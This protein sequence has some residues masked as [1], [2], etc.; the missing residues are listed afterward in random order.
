MI[1]K[2]KRL[3][4][5]NKMRLLVIFPLIFII[6]L[7][8]FITTTSYKKEV[9][10]KNV[11][12]LIVLNTKISLLLHETQKERGA[13]A[14]YLGSKGKKFKDILEKQRNLTNERI[15]EFKTYL[16]GFSY[17]PSK[18]KETINKV[19]DDLSKI[20]K[21]RS[22]IDKL[23]IKAKNAIGFYTNLNANLLYFIAKSSLIAE[24][25]LI[26]K[27][28]TAYY[29]FLMSKERAGIERAVGSNVF[30][31]GTF[32]P[33]VFLKFLTLINEQDAYIKSFYVYNSEKEEYVREKFKNPI[34]DEVQRMRDILLS[35]DEN[36][37]IVFDV[38]P[39]Y[40]FTTITKKINILKEVDDY[41][42]K[43]IIKE[44]S[45]IE[46]N[47]YNK[48][49]L[50]AILS[51]VIITIVLLFV[52]FFIG[53]INRGIDKI[54]YGIEDFIKYLNKE[55]NEVEY[56][57][58]G[59]KGS[60][61]NLAKMINSNID[62]MNGNLEKDL[63]CVGEA[64]ITLDKVEKGYY[65]CRVKSV[66]ANPQVR[67]L[68]NTINKMLDNQQKVI[69]DILKVLDEYTNY[70]YLSVINTK[71]LNGESLQMVEGINGL[72]ESITSMLVE[73]K[74]NGETLQKGSNQ[75]LKNVDELNTAS[76][77]A[78]ARLEET[79]AA[80]EEI[81]SNINSSSQNIAQMAKNANELTISANDGEKLANKTVSSMDDINTQ[82][83]AINEAITVID[84]IAFQTNIL[85]LNAAVEAATAGEAGKGFAV[86]AQEVRNLA[87]R[88]AEA[89]NEI[90]TL[91]ENASSKSKEG[92][93]IADLM[94]NGYHN[95]NE[96]ISNTLSLIDEVENS[97]KEQKYGIEQISDA[98]NSLDKQTQVNANI[99]NHTNDI[100]GETAS[101]AKNVVE[102]TSSKEFR[103]K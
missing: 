7:S 29:N 61:G 75:L 23:E 41:L 72:G 77:D 38:E 83:S 33:G 86:V 65:S 82:V 101:L 70:N 30:A 91:V 22:G 93:D 35:Y 47:E 80:V 62:R 10:L 53:S 18:G 15:E 51:I 66:A 20:Q 50:I 28:I 54:Y 24:D 1:L 26:I 71:D 88:S 34:V 89:A 97:A 57:K 25:E 17:Y 68:A 84:Q 103:G 3:S 45:E 56:I 37:D 40:W 60:L 21:L 52:I 87:S 59:T 19:L 27:N 74:V 55:V 4:V 49:L 100:A 99:A 63:L 46:E 16:N 94:I 36:R 12:D 48:M 13:S 11:K 6:G 90:K 96:N 58:L 5:E 42:S 14:G 95:L 43:S 85:S 73:N 31:E 8:L 9:K 64:T 102:A 69:N 67:I 32:A 44:I 98:I 81:S 76:N 79:A 92:K 39:T 78:A 2:L